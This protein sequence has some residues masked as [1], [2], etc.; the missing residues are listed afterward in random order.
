VALVDL[1]PI[2]DDVTGAIQALRRGSPGLALV[3]ISGSA[4][5][6][7]QG[8]DD[9]STVWVRK[10]FEIGEILAALSEARAAK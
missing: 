1:S 10:P 7:P 8:F 4:A 5:G 6:L 2:A 3:F 9:E